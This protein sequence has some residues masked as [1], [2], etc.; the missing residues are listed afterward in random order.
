MDIS[1]IYHDEIPDFI[2]EFASAEAMTRLKNIGMNCGLEYTS[3]PIYGS[4]GPCSRYEHSLGTALIVWH[5]TKEMKQ[6]L[7]GLFHD[8]STPV[9]A[10]VVDFLNKDYMEQES[11]EEKTRELIVGSE[12]ICRLL[13]KYK[14]SP[15][16]VCDYHRYPIADNDSPRLSADRLEYTLS[17]AIS[18]QKRTYAE[19][20]SYYDDLTVI[21][22]EDNQPELAFKN[23]EPASA[24]TRTAIVNSRLYVADADRYSMQFLADNLRLA[25][26]RGILTEDDLYTTEPAVINKLKA[27][28]ETAEL[29]TKFR[30][31][32]KI[33]TQADNPGKPYWISV[34]AKKRY[35]NP[36]VAGKGRISELNEDI[37]SQI[38]DFLRLD[39]DYWMLAE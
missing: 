27:H 33:I 24:F 13:D 12:A 36:L 6:A 39:Y 4:C 11:T 29:W 7:A 5:F 23:E 31:F 26:D 18:F 16:E 34:P 14:I 22:N 35:I 9:F 15:E 17:N 28:K 10:H 38:E 3:F 8:I 19:V 2:R 37:K 32:S 30:S 21:S 25:L 1:A 20:K